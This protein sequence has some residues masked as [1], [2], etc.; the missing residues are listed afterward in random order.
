M[1]LDDISTDSSVGDASPQNFKVTL[2]YDSEDLDT[3]VGSIV[4]SS[5]ED[6]PLSPGHNIGRPTQS[7]QTRPLSGESTRTDR[8]AG[9]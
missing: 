8:R 3:P 6:V 7:T 9:V 5:D 1:D 4:F 2:L